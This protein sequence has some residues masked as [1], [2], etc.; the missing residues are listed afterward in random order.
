MSGNKLYCNLKCVARA[1]TLQQAPSSLRL[2]VRQPRQGCLPWCSKKHTVATLC[3]KEALWQQG[4]SGE[5]EQTVECEVKDLA[6]LRRLEADL[7]V[8]VKC[9]TKGRPSKMLL[10]D[11]LGTLLDLMEGSPTSEA[12]LAFTVS[13]QEQQ[14]CCQPQ[15]D[16]GGA[17]VPLPH[18]YDALMNAEDS[19]L[20]YDD[21]WEEIPLEEEE[22][23]SLEAPDS[24]VGDD[25]EADDGEW[26]TF[27]NPS[28][29]RTLRLPRHIEEEAV[30]RW[31][32]PWVWTSLDDLLSLDNVLSPW[33]TEKWRGPGAWTSEDDLLSVRA[34]RI[35]EGIQPVVKKVQLPE[36]PQWWEQASPATAPVIRPEEQAKQQDIGLLPPDWNL[37]AFP[38]IHAAPRCRGEADA[39]QP[40]VA[41]SAPSHSGEADDGPPEVALPAPRLDG[42]AARGSMADWRRGLFIV[43]A[44]MIYA[45]WV[46]IW[47]DDFLYAISDW[48]DG[49]SAGMDSRSALTE[50]SHEL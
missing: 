3:F 47:G 48:L 12:W 19:S 36:G 23:E 2:S 25:S 29:G 27:V 14:V 31:R 30:E 34:L 38:G 39:G 49:F 41:L 7:P 45:T 33:G 44:Y 13:G 42:R 15:E 4:V 22:E 5:Y 20:E 40:E 24:C 43:V 32:A 16:Q 1:A 6:R 11:S 17:G 28:T 26:V 8:K 35:L 18:S 37:P 9:W 46:V 21:L 50:P 10:Q